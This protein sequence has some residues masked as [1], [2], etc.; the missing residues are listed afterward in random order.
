MK[1]VLTAVFDE[2]DGHSAEEE[3]TYIREGVD[4][5]TSFAQAMVF[6]ANATGYTYVTDAGFTS[7]NGNEWWGYNF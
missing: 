4:D 1:L 2:D 6:F 7:D 3:V 5:M